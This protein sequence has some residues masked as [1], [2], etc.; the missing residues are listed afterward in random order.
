M[1]PI[2]FELTSLGFE[3]EAVIPDIYSCKGDDTSPELN[4]GVPP[5]GTE[6]LAL[7]FDDPDAPGG[8]WVHWIVY[9]L[10]GELNGMPPDYVPQT[11]APVP[12]ALGVNSW[13]RAEYGGPCPPQGST[14]RYVFT[15]YALD[16]TLSFDAPPT[17]AALLAAMEGHI[18]DQ[19]VLYGTF[20][21]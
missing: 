7:I 21:R 12:G 19:S 14:H 2:P 9:N 3:N 8:T 13:G 4:W 11:G 6:S 20:T 18:L 15:V 17:K 10:P 1:T 16:T 5:T